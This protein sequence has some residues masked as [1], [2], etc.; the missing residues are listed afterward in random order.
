LQAISKINELAPTPTAAKNVTIMPTKYIGRRTGP[1]DDLTQRIMVGNGGLS[2]R[3][4][5]MIQ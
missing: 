2:G 5:A 1:R 4:Y 3:C